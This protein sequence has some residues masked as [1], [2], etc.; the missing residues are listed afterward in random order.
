MYGEGC[1]R[2]FRVIPAYDTGDRRTVEASAQASSHPD[3]APQVQP[4]AVTEEVTEPLPL[5]LQGAVEPA[6]EI[7]IPIF[8]YRDAAISEDQ[9]APFRENLDTLEVAFLP[10]S[11]QLKQQSAP[12]LLLIE[13]TGEQGRVLEG[14]YSDPK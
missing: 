11:R 10:V 13:P 7:D 6:G 4:D 2:N 8:R 9:I 12:D 3:V 1:V 5:L 14:L